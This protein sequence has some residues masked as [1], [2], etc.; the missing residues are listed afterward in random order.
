M[1]DRSNIKVRYEDGRDVYL[2]GH[3]MGTDNGRIVA[4]CMSESSRVTDSAYFTR[5][6]FQKMID[7]DTSELGYGI[8]TM[9]QDNQYPIVVVDYSRRLD[10]GRP[11]VYWEGD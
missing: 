1:G 4:E 8:S 6:L 2:Y 3:W 5:A 7:G 10:D 9:I 11:I